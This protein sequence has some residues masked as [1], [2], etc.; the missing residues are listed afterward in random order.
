[1]AKG[2]SVASGNWFLLFKYCRWYCLAEAG[3]KTPAI[4]HVKMLI[5]F[6]I[7]NCDAVYVDE[8]M[9]FLNNHINVLYTGL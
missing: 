5:W 9:R 4:A 2:F 8:F 3:V 1:M 6:S 7:D